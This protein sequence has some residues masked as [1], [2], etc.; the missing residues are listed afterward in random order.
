MKFDVRSPKPDFGDLR[1]LTRQ[2]GFVVHSDLRL[3]PDR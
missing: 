1:R 3:R 2:S